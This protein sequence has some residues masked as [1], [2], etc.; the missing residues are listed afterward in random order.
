MTRI[1]APPAAPH[2]SRVLCTTAPDRTFPL[3]ESVRPG[4]APTAG[5]RVAL[6]VCRSCPLQEVCRAEVL[7]MPLR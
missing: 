4:Q 2:T 6:A 7:E 5:E 3:E 1:A